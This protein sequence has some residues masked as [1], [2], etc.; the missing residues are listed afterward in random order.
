LTVGA[1]VIAVEVHQDTA[2][3]SDVSFDAMLWGLAAAGPSLTVTRISA[4]QVEVSWPLSTDPTALLYF[5]T[6]LNA[7]NWSLETA[8]DA[9]SGGFHHVTVTTT[10]ARFWT[11]RK[12]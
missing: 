10:T 3:S 5:K 2:N 8:L 11:L 4:T 12:P 6:D 1:N 7:A 9:P